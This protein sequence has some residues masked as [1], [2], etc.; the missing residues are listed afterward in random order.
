MKKRITYDFETRS[1]CDLKKSGAYKYSMHPSTQATCLAFKE[2]GDHRVHLFEFET[3]NS[4]WIDIPFEKRIRWATYIA[5]GWEFSAHNSFFERCIYDNILVRRHG[6]PEIQ[7]DRRR[8]TAAKA[9]ACA[10]PRSLQGA[11]EALNLVTQKDRNGYVAMMATCKPTKEWVFWDK[12]RK[13]TEEPAVFLEPHH[14]PN[15]WKTLYD[16]CRIDVQ[17]EEALDV[18]LPDLTSEEQKVWHLNQQI[19]W[20]GLRID[21]PLVC[22]IVKIIEEESETKLEEL[23]LLTMGLV[24]RPGAR[25]AIL[26]FLELERVKIPDLKKQTV[27]DSLKD[28]DM[29]SDMHRLLQLRKALSLTST[30][31]YQSFLN[32]ANEDGRVRDLLLYHGA[33]TGRETGI[34]IQPQNFPRGLIW[35]DKERPYAAVN[36]VSECDKEMLQ[37]L[38]GE[39][40]GI[41]FSAILR[42][43]I[44]PS[45]GYE[46]FVADFAKIEVAVL[47]WLADNEKGLKVLR[48]GL[49][50]YRYMA[51][52]NSGKTYEEMSDEGDARQLGKAQVLGCGFGMGPDKFQKTAWDMYR[53]NLTKDQSIAAVN[54]YR[55]TNPTVPVLWKTYENAAI[56]IVEKGN[57]KGQVFAVRAGHCVFFMKNNFLWIRLPSGRCLAYR[58]PKITMREN[59]YGIQ[60]SLEFHAVNSKTKKWL[61]ERTWGGTLTEN[62]V[63]A[64]ARDLMM[65]GLIRLED[66]GYRAVLTVHDEV[67]CEKRH[68]TGD[69]ERFIRVLCERPPW[70]EGLPV[71]AKGWKGARYR[72]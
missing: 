55:K 60:K 53:L 5:E 32:R 34:G 29:H 30:K 72:K 1:R 59:Q 65:Q 28:F 68:N 20:R 31:K 15:I 8:C 21:I 6:W 48:G 47:W 40:L 42:S 37:L 56:Q 22:K 44:I 57:P 39:S 62:I 50:P 12:K 3:V 63:Q 49:D 13:T 61:P 41:L 64:V 58:E 45:E 9:S 66:V 26:D 16:Y 46:F 71:T 23:D 54:Y 67:I 19:N 18:A 11:G 4:H 51:A 52:A 70:A 43:M 35:V 38:Y 33:S 2:W 36:N 69:L 14:A 25:K 10:L 27:E 24:T 7:A 17:A